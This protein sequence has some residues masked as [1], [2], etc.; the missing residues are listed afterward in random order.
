[1]VRLVFRRYTQIRRSICTSESLRASTSV[2]A[3][4]ALFR[5]SSPSFGSQHVRSYSNLSVNRT[6]RSMMLHMVASHLGAHSLS[7]RPRVSIT[8][9]LAHMLDS[10][11]RVSRRVE[12]GRM[13]VGI[14]DAS[15][16]SIELSI[17]GS[18]CAQACRPPQ[19]TRRADSSSCQA[20]RHASQRRRSAMG[21][22]F[23]RL[24][25]HMRFTFL[26]CFSPTTER[27]WRLSAESAPIA[28]RIRSRPVRSDRE[29]ERRG[30][31]T[32]ESDRANC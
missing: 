27:C 29:H 32:T 28:R 14:F 18:S 12:W 11:V 3:G 9:R 24:N 20:W 15:C 1:M 6:G 7:L 19:S 4:F 10:L 8:R 22:A 5:H 2:S 25:N 31:R 21:Q 23:T 17:G 16:A 26:E 30:E 13:I